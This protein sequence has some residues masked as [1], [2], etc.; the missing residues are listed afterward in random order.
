MKSAVLL[1]ACA[2]CANAIH[3]ETSQLSLQ[4]GVDRSSVEDVQLTGLSSLF[5]MSFLGLAIY[6]AVY[7]LGLLKGIVVHGI[8]AEAL[9][10]AIATEVDA[11]TKYHLKSL[12]NMDI[13]AAANPLLA[14]LDKEASGVLD[15]ILGNPLLQDGAQKLQAGCQEALEALQGS[16]ATTA[17]A[18]LDIDDECQENHGLLADCDDEAGA[19]DQW[20]TE[21]LDFN[22]CPEASASDVLLKPLDFTEDLQVLPA[23]PLIFDEAP[24]PTVVSDECLGL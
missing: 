24:A 2:C 17:R 6:F 20:F 10:D 7:R 1:A 23:E 14:G 11:N 18:M 22:Q 3:L 9:S 13:V 12:K 21:K 8:Q 15:T 5:L 19:T 16:A 4:T